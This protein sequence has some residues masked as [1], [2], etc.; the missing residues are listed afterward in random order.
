MVSTRVKQSAFVF[1]NFYLL[2]LTFVIKL[3]HIVFITSF[4]WSIV[5]ASLLISY[6][7]LYRIKIIV[8]FPSGLSQGEEGVITHKIERM[9]FLLPQLT[10]Q[11]LLPPPLVSIAPASLSSLEGRGGERFFATK[12]G[13]YRIKA[14][15]ITGLDFLGIFELKRTQRIEGEII[16]YP[17]YVKFSPVIPFGGGGEEGVGG[18]QPARGGVEFAAVR[19]WQQGESEKDIHW[20]LMAKWGR[21][22]VVLHTQAGS[23]S[24]T[25]AIDCSPKAVF[26]DLKDNTFELSLKVAA[27][28]SWA[29]ISNGGEVTLLYAKQDGESVISRHSSFISVLE[30]LARLEANSPISLASLL[31]SSPFDE[32]ASLT[33]LTSLPDNSLIPFLQKQA[34]SGNT[35]FLLLMDGA[36]FGRKGWFAGDFIESV[37]GL[38]FVSV[39]RREDDLKE[40]LEKIW[41]LLCSI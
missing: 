35:P 16:I 4:F 17:S 19:E 7:F 36:S 39:I 15:R 25:I 33:I 13:V 14:L 8:E 40:R 28:L 23:R 34:E 1:L 26:G 32:E 29:T 31:R 5:L 38:S 30:E 3:P 41:G 12:R 24:Q 20:K 6:L 21:P 9:R 37:R 22:F 27:S 2:I 11:T 18:S 10:S